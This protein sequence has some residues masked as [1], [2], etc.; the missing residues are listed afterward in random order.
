[1][2]PFA[3]LVWLFGFLYRWTVQVLWD[4]LF[5]AFWYIRMAFTRTPGK[6]WRE[7]SV[8][9][10]QLLDEGSKSFVAFQ[11]VMSTFKYSYDGVV[12]K[13][14]RALKVF[15]MWPTWMCTVRI[16]VYKG[17]TGNCQDA[18]K[19]ACALLRRLNKNV[20]SLELEY[21]KNVYLPLDPTR[22]EYTHY[23]VSGWMQE[24]IS[25]I[26]FGVS[27]SHVTKSMRPDECA[28][29]ILNKKGIYQYVWVS[30]KPCKVLF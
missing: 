13:A 15:T 9:R 16:S 2:V 26:P 3:C 25:N 11:K 6:R 23:I 4:V 18:A 10:N 19:V 1:M 24:G 14:P 5:N 20:P 30:R 12:S 8:K 7:I 28:S 29:G 27:N 22:L 17:F 21:K